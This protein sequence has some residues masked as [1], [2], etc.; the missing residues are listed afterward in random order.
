MSQTLP[1][2][3]ASFAVDNIAA[4]QASCLPQERVGGHPQAAHHRII[5]TTTHNVKTWAS[6]KFAREREKGKKN[7]NGSRV[8][9]CCNGG[10]AYLGLRLWL[11]NYINQE[12]KHFYRVYRC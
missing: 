7:E 11:R 1:V 12:I 8:T 5:P 4:L 6:Y 10:R 9:V 2:L 3:V